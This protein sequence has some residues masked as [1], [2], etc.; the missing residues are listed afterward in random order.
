MSEEAPTVVL[1]HPDVIARRR[2]MTLYPPPLEHPFAGARDANG[3]WNY[4]ADPYSLRKHMLLR[5]RD[6]TGRPFAT[7]KDMLAAPYM[8][9]IDHGEVNETEKVCNT[10]LGEGVEGADGLKVLRKIK[11]DAKVPLP[12][13]PQDPREP[14]N[15]WNSEMVSSNEMAVTCCNNLEVQSNSTY[16]KIN[17]LQSP[18]ANDTPYLNSPDPPKVFC[19]MYTYHKKHYLLEAAAQSWAFKCDGFLAFSDLTDPSIGAVDLP[20][21]GTESYNNMW[22]KVRS[23]WCYIYTN[24]YD[25]FDYFHLGGDDT[26]MIVENLRNYLWSIDDDNGTKPLYIGGAY[27][28]KG[29]MVCG[30][31]PG[32]T[33]NKVTLK[34]LVTEAFAKPDT[35]ADSGEDRLMGH[36]LY[37][38]VRCYDTHDANGAKRYLGWSP[39]S[40]GT[41]CNEMPCSD[42]IAKQTKYWQDYVKKNISGVD[43]VSSQG[44]SFHWLRNQIMLKR[45][46]A[47]LYHTCPS[48]TLIGL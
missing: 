30:G 16:F 19:G 13:N 36:T 5:Y 29:V 17:I 41:D 14:P 20:H 18:S 11:I 37:P 32:Y 10:P 46:Y 34:W 35:T 40:Y 47:I 28:A 1:D 4:V 44:V 12:T 8:P 27:K 38:F 33:L 23:I 3:H 26:M 39:A 24:Y 31:G 43:L 21:Y 2:N 22:Q 15:G 9:L 25:D 42:F 7:T 45:V 48:N 6:D